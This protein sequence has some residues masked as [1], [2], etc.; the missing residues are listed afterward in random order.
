MAA[1]LPT[2]STL[3]LLLRPYSSLIL[4]IVATPKIAGVEPATP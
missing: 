3:Y 1:P 4:V 2:Q